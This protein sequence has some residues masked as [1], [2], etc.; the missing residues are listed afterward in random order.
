M[1]PS[2]NST[3]KRARFDALGPLTF[4]GWRWGLTAIILGLAASFFFCGYA[5]AFWR[6][7]D[8]DFMV[9]YNAFLLNDGKPQQFFDHTGYLTIVSVKTWFETL[10]RLGLLDSW[11]LSSMPPAS[12]PEA[13]NAAMTSAVRAG[14]L[15]AW[16]IA[17]G[18]VLIFAG[19][20]RAIARDWPLAL[21]ATF[22]F[23]FS[24]GLAVHARILRTE[25]VAACPVL[26]AL[27]ILIVIG[28]RASLARPLLIALA[29]ALCMLG[30]E[31][32][33]QAFLLVAALPVLILPFGGA[34]SASV[35]FWRSRR[36]ALPVAV[37]SLVAAA[38]A[39]YAAWPLIATGFDRTLLDAAGFRPLL[40]GRFGIYQAAV[41]F[42]I[43]GCMLIYAAIWR[44]SAAETIVSMA[45]AAAGATLA[46]LALN[47]DYNAN[48]VIAVFNPLEKMLMFVDA[49][50]AEAANK[51]GFADIFRLLLD[52]IV[53]VAARYSFVLHS[54][55]RPT[56]FLTWL[57]VPG[58]AYAW[59]RGERQAAIQAL[60]LL[61][62]SIGID[63]LGVRRALKSEYFIITDP[64]IVLA[65]ALLLDRLADLRFHRWAF[66]IA[67][68]LF[69]LHIVVS[70]AE[71]VK[72]ALQRRGPESVCEWNQHYM[73]LMPLPWCPA[74][75][76]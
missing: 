27:M 10:H 35:A 54:S 22:A 40:L 63:A 48:N 11:S 31:N 13:F 55:P 73:P 1:D 38:A 43:G 50:T 67:A 70:Q 7:A 66:P 53:S 42:L 46:L 9:I 59:S 26:F 76:S 3:L 39:A 30:L 65:G 74:T 41:L 68:V 61:A 75:R 24:G 6:N 52:G 15:L 17:T 2:A 16:L 25:L 44:I 56:V 69:G 47:L 64:L 23:A 58:I 51:P 34:E 62:V 21:I 20:M 32:K 36:S 28:R 5:V 71:P 57:I 14:R 60:L 45:A 8:M 33:V 19:L 12:N 29:A 72:Y 4:L 49:G 37:A 18:T